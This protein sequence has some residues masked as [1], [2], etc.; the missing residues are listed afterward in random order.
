MDMETVGQIKAYDRERVQ[1]GYVLYSAYAGDRVAIVDRGGRV[2][3]DWKVGP[4]VKIS[5]LLP[6]GRLVYAQMGHAMIEVDWEGYELWRYNC[7]QHHDF[8]RY[9]DGRIIVLTNEISFNPRIWHG[10]NALTACFYEID[11]RGNVLWE[12]RSEDHI[13]EL[14]DMAGVQFPAQRA[15]WTHCNTV[16]ALPA[17]PLGER[18]HRFHPGNVLFSFTALG[19]IGVIDRSSGKIVWVWGKGELDGV[20][21]PTMLSNGRLLI[22]NNGTERGWS[23]VLEL[24]PAQEAI[25]W[26]FRLPDGIYGRALAG[27]ELLPNGNILICSG[28]PGV[29]LEVNRDKEILWEYHNTLASHYGYD[30]GWAAPTAVYR[31]MFCPSSWVERGRD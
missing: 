24:D 23:R 9:P 14:I 6:D 1:P 17:T 13:D 27:Q 22:F 11:R 20:H 18:D 29:L 19:L 15:D 4:Y 21:M 7:R 30:L 8:Y 5:E 2:V 16:E 25:T 28:T 31:A 26:E 10:H 3:H 12:W